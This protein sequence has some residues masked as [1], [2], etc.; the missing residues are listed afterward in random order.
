PDASLV[1]RDIGR[2]L[3][4]TELTKNVLGGAVTA[5]G[6]SPYTLAGGAPY[7]PTGGAYVGPPTLAEFA[8]PGQPAARQP[9]NTPSLYSTQTGGLSQLELGWS[10]LGA[11]LNN[12]IP[13]AA[14]NFTPY[15]VLTF[16]TALNF[17]DWRNYMPLADFDVQLTDSTGKTAYTPVSAWSKALAYPP[18]KI[19]RL[20][21][22]EMN[23]VRIPLSTFAGVDLSHIVSV[24]FVFDRQPMGAVL[25]TDLALSD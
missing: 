13:A 21:K 10:K 11:T 17:T 20:P 4:P 9:G 22:V 16:R 5:T 23:G 2:F 24:R 6:L 25:L 12:A 3:S 15:S 14:G 1:R 19:A 7:N 18:G 8:L